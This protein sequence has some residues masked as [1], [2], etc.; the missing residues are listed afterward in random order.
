MAEVHGRRLPPVPAVPAKAL[1]NL[2]AVLVVLGGAK[3]PR[4][5][6]V[7]WQEVEWVVR[8]GLAAALA[9][10][11]HAAA[12][13]AT[14]G[15]RHA[16]RIAAIVTGLPLQLLDGETRA[17]LAC[18][19]VATFLT[20]G[21]H[22]VT[23]HWATLTMMLCTAQLLFVWLFDP[24]AHPA[25]Y[26]RFLDSAAGFIPP[27]NRK[28][29]RESLHEGR[30]LHYSLLLPGVNLLH[31]V[32]AY[33]LQHLSTFSLKF[34]A[35]LYVWRLVYAAVM[36]QP[37]PLSS[38]IRD[39]LR[40]AFFLSWYGLMAVAGLSTAGHLNRHVKVTGPLLW[41]LLTLPGLSILL[42]SSERRRMLPTYC[43]TFVLYAL[44]QQVRGLGDGLLFSSLAAATD[45]RPRPALLQALWC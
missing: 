31:A 14:D 28:L 23:R 33:L 40:S 6:T 34:Y 37:L 35:K 20:R 27:A 30:P 29:L 42:E 15:M 19:L 2:A 16:D 22:R 18:H 7:R 8:A 24:E 32:A 9:P 44:V 45:L 10:L 43:L 1:R 5:R 39:T 25:P 41:L 38:V 36:K 12:A 3:L 4:Y 17:T 21:L 11:V 26:Q 13:R